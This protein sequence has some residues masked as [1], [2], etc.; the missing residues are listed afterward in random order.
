MTKPTP[1]VLI[2]GNSGSGKST[3]AKRLCASHQCAHL[4]L[5]T[6]AWLPTQPPTRQ[7][8][9]ESAVEIDAFMARNDAWVIEGCYT[10][11]L[12]LAKIRARELVLMDISVSDCQANARGRPFEPHKYASKEEQDRN[13]DM[14]L[15]WIAQYAERDD[16]FSAAAHRSFFE[17]FGGTRHRLVNNAQSRA[18]ELTH[19]D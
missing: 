1:R 4:D 14:L 2:L 18:F 3:L 8:L 11:L 13:L 10:D 16:T 6:L 12:D 15:A 19:V 9:G 5:D 7:P 17:S